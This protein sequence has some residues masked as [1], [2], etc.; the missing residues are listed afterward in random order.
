MP[1][2]ISRRM[3]SSTSWSM[4]QS[5]WPESSTK[6]LQQNAGIRSHRILSLRQTNISMTA[7]S[8]YTGTTR[9]PL[10]T[11]MTGMFG[12]SKPFWPSPA[13]KVRPYPKP[14]IVAGV[15]MGHMP[16][17]LALPSLHLLAVSNCK[18]TTLP[19]G[20]QLLWT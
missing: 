13:A 12:P 3:Q 8:D 16:P 7:K 15:D 20:Q 17:K 10:F 18:L 2:G 4:R 9:Q 1:G 6:A 14:Y 5:S 11:H 19:V